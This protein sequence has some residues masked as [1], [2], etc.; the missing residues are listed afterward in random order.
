MKRTVIVFGVALVV[1]FALVARSRAHADRLNAQQRISADLARQQRAVEEQTRMQDR[2]KLASARESLANG[3]KPGPSDAPAKAVQTTK[4]RPTYTTPELIA[5]NPALQLAILRQKRAEFPVLF[6]PLCDS[7]KLPPEQREKLCELL[8]QMTETNMDLAG[9]KLTLGA[10]VSPEERALKTQFRAKLTEL[11][12]PEG[13]SAFEVYQRSAPLRNAF[14]APLAGE[15]ALA[16]HPLSAQQGERL[17]Q[18]MAETSPAKPDVEIIS[19]NEVNWDAVVSRASTV[20]QG[21]QLE[22][23]K[24]KAAREKSNAS[25]QAALD[26]W[27]EQPKP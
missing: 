20:L 27:A 26:H 7:L 4:A 17:V 6:G 14:V 5:A 11:L 10:D 23:F 3:A 22:A 16:G 19:T 24:A 15:F 21:P 1:A 12:G 2:L 18:I 25:L 8:M 9:A 13:T